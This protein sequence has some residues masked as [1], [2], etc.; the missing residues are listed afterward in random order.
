MSGRFVGFIYVLLAFSVSHATGA[1]LSISRQVSFELPRAPLTRF[2]KKRL[3]AGVQNLGQGSI[4][5]KFRVPKG[6]KNS[7]AIV[8]IHTCHD[9]DFYDPWMER[10]NDWGYVTFQ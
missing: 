9:K 7:P 4:T 2:Q 3:P 8:A 1:E 5:A 10:L 6:L